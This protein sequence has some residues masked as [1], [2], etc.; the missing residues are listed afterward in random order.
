M[1]LAEKL[2]L[3]DV[4]GVL[5]DWQYAFDRWMHRHGY[6]KKSGRQ[7]E[8]ALESTYDLEREDIVRLI[9]M[10]NESAAIAY[11]PPLRDAM[12]WVRRLHQDHGY[13]FYAITSMSDDPFAARLREKNLSRVFGE[14]VFE[15][16][17]CLPM[18]GCK[19]SE[20]EKFEDTGCLWVEDKP[21]NVL[22]GQELGLDAITMR[23][24]YNDGRIDM[25]YVD[26]WEEI[27]WRMVK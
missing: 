17:I 3:V 21:K 25:E 26:N 11:L 8:Y 23:H 7:I 5:L 19:R 9:S 10:F 1:K 20:L 12:K 15:R 22:D 24:N 2:I 16:V 18:D 27:Y 13:M 4:D 14:T 6:Q